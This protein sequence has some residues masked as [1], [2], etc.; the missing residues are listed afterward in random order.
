M[1]RALLSSYIGSCACMRLPFAAA[2]CFS[3]HHRQ[4]GSQ[5]FSVPGSWL[6]ADS[7]MAEGIKSARGQ[8]KAKK[9]KMAHTG[10]PTS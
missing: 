5:F 2:S 7:M 3:C 8:Q 1:R 4:G 9:K 10:A 6:A